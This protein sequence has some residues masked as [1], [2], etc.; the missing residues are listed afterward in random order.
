MPQIKA[1]AD[2]RKAHG[3]TQ[4]TQASF[5]GIARS[6]LA[7]YETG[8]LAI[9]ADILYRLSQLYHLPMDTLYAM[10]RQSTHDTEEVSYV[11]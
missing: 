11:P 5:L 10:S 1:L 2:L 8:F 4:E 6:T 7:Q 3:M 9:P